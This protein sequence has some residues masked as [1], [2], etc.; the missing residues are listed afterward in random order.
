[1]KAETV[2]LKYIMHVIQQVCCFQSVDSA[3]ADLL[4]QMLTVM[5]MVHTEGPLWSASK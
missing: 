1:M 2:V 5:G 3:S 4:N